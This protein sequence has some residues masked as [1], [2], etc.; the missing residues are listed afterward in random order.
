MLR[1]LSLSVSDK[2]RE[3]MGRRRVNERKLTTR[4]PALGRIEWARAN[5]MPAI[6]EPSVPVGKIGADR[7]RYES[8][9]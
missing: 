1:Q 7:H 3:I 6:C 4:H 5:R 8:R 2:A 9:R